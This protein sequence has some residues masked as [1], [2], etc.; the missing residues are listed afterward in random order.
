MVLWRRVFAC[1]ASGC[2][3]NPNF[4]SMSEVNGVHNSE[5]SSTNPNGP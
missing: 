4:A 2:R 3:S 5:Y 1:A